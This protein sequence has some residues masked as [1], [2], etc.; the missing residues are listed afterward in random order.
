MPLLRMADDLPRPVV[1]S[2]VPVFCRPE[3]WHLHRQVAG[4]RRWRAHII[5]RRR[6]GPAT[7]PF[8]KRWVTVLPQYRWRFFRRL[9]FTQ[10]RRV[11]WQVSDSELKRLLFAI[12]T[13]GASVVHIYFGHMAL[14]L[15]PVLRVSPWPVVVSFHGADT[16]VDMERP[17]QATRM[18]EVF[19]RAARILGRSQSLLDDLRALGC[20]PEKLRLNRTG[21]PLDNFPVVP[22]Q[23]PPD[24]RWV[25]FQAGRLIGKKGYETSLAALARIRR[26]HPRTVLRVAGDGPLRESLRDTAR[27]LGVADAVEWLGFLAQDALRES[28]ATAHVF[29]HPSEMDADGNREGVPNAL[30]EA[31]ATGLPAVATRHGGIPEAIDHGVSGLLVPERAPDEL[32]AAVLRFLDDPAEASGCGAQGAASVRGRYSGEAS[33]RA[34]E[35]IYDEVVATIEPAQP[36]P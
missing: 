2:Y 22:R 10:I 23:P 3:M 15:L 6:E 36:P 33:I 34:L 19:A 18:R 28:L 13:H 24:G 32:A 9:W 5:T 35:E 30:L 16:G 21:I 31:M 4:L 12:Q 27:A 26:T 1:A 20:P 29:L 7:F 17:T 8:H 25:L 14:H 11:P